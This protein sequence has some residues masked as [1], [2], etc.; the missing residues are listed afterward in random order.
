MSGNQLRESGMSG[1]LVGM[2]R[3]STKG[4][5]W[6]N[7]VCNLLFPSACLFCHEPFPAGT[8]VAG[9]CCGDCFQQIK[10]WPHHTCR[11]CGAV[12]SESLAPGPCGACLLKVPVQQQTHSLFTY[13]GPVRDAILNWKLQGSDGAV[14]WLIERA[15]PQ[16]KHLIDSSDLLI[17]VPMPLS[18][19]RRSG[20]HHSADLCRWL[21]EGRGC[22]WDWQLLRRVGEQPRQSELSGSAR[23][24]NL[25]KAF[26]LAVD[27][28]SRLPGLKRIWIVDDILTT[29]STLHYAA[30]ACRPLKV[31][32]RVLSLAR[33]LNRG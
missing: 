19:M 11:C 18:R 10:I 24:K 16:I 26:A 33:T 23:R 12:I 7:G 1:M 30:R 25:C 13:A 3:L 14:R 28:Q 17:P 32:V 6:V 29:G 15:M 22:H 4:F 27:Y 8:T 5:S 21:A 9:G 2:R 20:C 31:E